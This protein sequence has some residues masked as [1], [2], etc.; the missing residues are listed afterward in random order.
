MIMFIDS[1]VSG[2]MVCLF[3]CVVTPVRH[4]ESLV[5]LAVNIW[6]CMYC[7]G[8]TLSCGEHVIKRMEI[9]S[10]SGSIWTLIYCFGWKLSP[11]DHMINHMK[12][13]GPILGY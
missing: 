5:V 6:T 12:R 9:N 3:T 10:L 13:S 1:P 2:I 11:G 8:P 7:F 4:A